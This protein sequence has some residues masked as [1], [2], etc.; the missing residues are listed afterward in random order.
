MPLSPSLRNLRDKLLGINDSAHR[1]AWGAAIGLFLGVFPGTG[2]LAALVMAFILRANK[3]AALAGALTVNT[4]INVVTFPIALA[5]GAYA[6]GSDPAVI[7]KEW[8]LATDPFIWQRF[9]SFLLHRA[10]L[11]LLAGYTVIG[12]ALGSVGYAA[13]FIVI[14]RIRRKRAA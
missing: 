8:S 5:I 7:T 3:A 2:V 13:T 1:I 12:L 9:L 11:S 6:S 14:T 4:W 10:I